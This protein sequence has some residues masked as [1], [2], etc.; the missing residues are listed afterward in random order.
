M[1]SCHCFACHPKLIWTCRHRNACKAS[2][3]TK[4]H[5]LIIPAHT[6][7]PPKN[8]CIS[9]IPDKPFAVPRTP[10][11]CPLVATTAISRL[12]TTPDDCDNLLKQDM[13]TKMRQAQEPIQSHRIYSVPAWKQHR[14]DHDCRHAKT[15]FSIP[16]SHQLP[17]PPKP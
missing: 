4:F 17:N 14:N 7:C 10:L 8:L 6:N 11:G 13:G 3:N 2:I 15:M 16:L 12:N 5:V 1:C 9:K